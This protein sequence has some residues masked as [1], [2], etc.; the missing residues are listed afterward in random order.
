MPERAAPSIAVVGS[1]NIDLIAY[2][3][4]APGPGETVMGDRFQMGFGGKGANQAVMA[5]R[6]G[7]RVSMVGALGDDVYADMTF[8]NLARQG[9]DA[10][11]VARVTGSSGVAPIWVEPDGTNRI[12]VVGGAND[13]VDPAVAAEAVRGMRRLDAV[14]G[15]LEIPQAVTTAAFQ[16]ARARGVVTILNPAPA[17]PLG[18]DLRAASD[19]IIPNEHELAL[20]VGGTVD[21]EDDA[22]LV[23]CARRLGPRLVVTLGSRGAALV[24]ADGSVT[25]VPAVPVRAIDTTGA[26]DA[27]VGAFGYGLA[28]G[29]DEATAVRL[30]IACASDS[31]TRPGTQSSFAARDGA[32]ALASKVLAAG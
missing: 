25:R 15:Q 32:A 16:A 7:A 18:G 9:I 14:I 21:L 29:F 27:F 5:A 13:A 8:D 20:I 12:I 24:R 23:E 26:G 22:A 31:V 1:L 10:A 3:Q 6:L 28:A 2:A 17:A 11:H 30:G 19:W 4:R